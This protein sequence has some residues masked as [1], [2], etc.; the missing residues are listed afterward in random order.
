MMKT[1]SGQ[2]RS[3]GLAFVAVVLAFA[4]STTTKQAGGLELIIRTDGLSAPGDFDDVRLEI[5]QQVDGGWNPLWNKDY[6]VPQETMLP[7]SFAIAAGRSPDQETLVR[8]IAL[9]G[10]TPVVLREA[11]VQVLRADAGRCRPAAGRGRARA[12][13]QSQSQARAQARA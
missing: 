10:S 13:A 3:I 5:S 1:R 7:A 4:C 11:Q 9:K 12:R 8:V 6:L 2:I